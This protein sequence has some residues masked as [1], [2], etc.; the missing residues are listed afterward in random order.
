MSNRPKIFVI[1]TPESYT[2]TYAVIQLI[3]HVHDDKYET[4]ITQQSR[5]MNLGDIHL[6]G[7]T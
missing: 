7:L 4:S 1:V 2:N 3:L 6:D 5:M